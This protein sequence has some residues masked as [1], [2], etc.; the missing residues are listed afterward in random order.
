MAK[1][2]FDVFVSV[3]LLLAFAPLMGLIA[4][5]VKATSRGPAIFKQQRLGYQKKPFTMFKFRT[6]I[7]GSGKPMDSV[8][9]GDKRVTSVGKFLR[10]SH[11][12]ELL[13]L[14]NV[15][16][17]DMSLVGPRP[18]SADKFDLFMKTYPD[19]EQR[20]NVKPGMTGLVQ[21]WGRRWILANRETAIALDNQ[22]VRQQSFSED[23]RILMQTISAVLRG[24][25]V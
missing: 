25:G 18:Y 6:M 10:S 4:C 3:I 14:W 11:L 21:V 9:V 24:R 17:G 22:Y 15:L 12:D 1:R 8:L 5:A 7:D 20:F 16:K 13:Q 2:I 23:L 19:Y